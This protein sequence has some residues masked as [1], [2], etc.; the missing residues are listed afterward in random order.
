MAY[1][2]QE[3]VQT[4]AA[5]LPVDISTS[6][7][8]NNSS[9]SAAG[10]IASGTTVASYMIH[11]ESVGA[12]F[13]AVFVTYV[14]PYPILGII[15]T[16]RRTRCDGLAA[17]QRRG[18]LYPTGLVNRGLELPFSITPDS[19]FWAGNQVSISVLSNTALVLDQLRVITAV[20][21]PSTLSLAAGAAI[22]AS[23]L[24]RYRRRV[25]A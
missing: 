25:R 13:S 17:R 12:A 19:V 9:P 23:L 2:F 15:T 24:L 5:S 22:G 7:L 1:L 20:P 8:Y 14:F 18:T 6:G 21:E 16:R 4:L 10:S 3:S 11:H